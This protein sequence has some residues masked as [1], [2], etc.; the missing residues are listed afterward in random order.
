MRE[1]IKRDQKIQRKN[2]RDQEIGQQNV[3]APKHPVPKYLRDSVKTSS[4]KHFGF[5][6]IGAKT[7]TP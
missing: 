3:S 1:K 2:I 5:K 4:P 7:L 6:L